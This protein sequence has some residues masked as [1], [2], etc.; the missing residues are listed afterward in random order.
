MSNPEVESEVGEEEEEEPIRPSSSID[1]GSL[2]SKANGMLNDEEK[3]DEPA[4]LNP[5]EYAV[6]V[7]REDKQSYWIKTVR[8]INQLM[9]THLQETIQSVLP[10]LQETLREQKEILDL[11]CEAA[12][13]YKDLLRNESLLEKEPSLV[14]TLLDYIVDNANRQKD[15]LSSAAWL[16]TLTDI[17]DT[18]P[19]DIVKSIVVPI[20][21]QQSNPSQKVQKRLMATKLLDKLVRI[22]SPYDIRH[23]FEKPIQQL[24]MDDYGTVRIS[25]AQRLTVVAERL[26]K[27]SDVSRI[28]LP[29]LV[30]L[31]E[32]ED[33]NV[34]EAALPSLVSLIHRITRDSKRSIVTPFFR[35]LVERGIEKK[36]DRI[37][38]AARYF[39]EL[40]VNLFDDMD[41]LDQTWALNSYIKLVGL[42]RTDLVK[43]VAAKRACAYNLPCL[44]Q[45]YPAASTRFASIIHDFCID[46]DDEVRISIAS[47]FDQLLS[48]CKEKKMMIG[49]FI[50]LVRGGSIE[51]VAKIASRFSSILPILYQSVADSPSSENLSP[52]SID[53]IIL[54]CNQI[55][56][57][58]G[59][60]RAHESLLHSFSSLVSLVDHKTLFNT[61]VPLLKTQILTVRG[62]PCREAASRSLLI[63]MRHLYKEEE[64]KEIINFFNN[65]LARHSNSYRRMIYLESVVQVHSIFS[66][67]VLHIHFLPTALSLSTDPVSNVRLKLCR[68]LSLLKSS[69]VLP[70]NEEMLQRCEGIVRSLMEKETLEHS[71]SQLSEMAR[72]FS[73]AD[74]GKK[75][76]AENERREKEEDELWN[77][78]RGEEIEERRKKKEDQVREK[79]L[80][81]RAS[82]EMSRS[83]IESSSPLRMERRSIAVVRPQP[84][85]HVRWHSP[86]PSP[87]P[88]PSPS[89]SPSTTER[90]SRLPL[91][92]TPAIGKPRSTV[93]TSVPSSS[94]S[95]NAARD[96]LRAQ[97]ETRTTSTTSSSTLGNGSNA[98]STSSYS[99]S[100]SQSSS[101]LRRPSFALSKVSSSSNI[102]RRPASMS[103]RIRN[104]NII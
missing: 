75:K 72:D 70:E 24:S 96:R 85:V 42:S 92:T 22:V 74:T 67:R 94:S 76:E 45:L 1:W 2:F 98:S 56:Q 78:K 36:D 38:L 11:H 60:W 102:E 97:S 54:G 64:R 86:A 73:R 66:H 87:S 80:Q 23:E 9:E 39:G 99:I 27:C 49:P 46:S 52:L 81:R 4:T 17:A 89:S 48:M 71:K 58:C 88:S 40:L 25:M 93:T 19:L 18:L 21:I 51:V 84:V 5:V 59:N 37:A 57:S 43:L 16:E 55:L 15:N 79:I 6:K 29:C 77:E 104:I 13:L 50:E 47:S 34:R 44:Y 14:M 90:K 53:R 63:L 101:H 31:S 41:I 68:I 95:S 62:V 69:F 83:L 33:A 28:V 100:K 12:V 82:R 35:K 10:Q 26:D 32:D 30:S 61:F 20:F 3:E 103:M 7:L 65:D 91:S 8:D